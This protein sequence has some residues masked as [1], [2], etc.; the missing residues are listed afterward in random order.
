MGK[1]RERAW[2]T[3][4]SSRCSRGR[5]APGHG[6]WSRST[7]PAG[8]PAT[9]PTK[10]GCAP[11]TRRLRRPTQV[12]Y[13]LGLLHRVG[14][15]SYAPHQDGL[16]PAPYRAAPPPNLLVASDPPIRYPTKSSNL[17]SGISS[18]KREGVLGLPQSFTLHR[19]R[20]SSSM[21]LVIATKSS[22]RSSGMF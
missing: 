11:S 18:R 17:S 15:P 13:G 5:P 4:T 22:L 19:D 2:Y 12:E 10:V 14:A 6:G 3:T 8:R 21:A 20:T 16:P 7:R 1:I 9:S